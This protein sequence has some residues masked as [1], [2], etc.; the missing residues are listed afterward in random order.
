MILR[1]SQKLSTKIKAGTLPPLPLHENPFA[2][3]SAHVFAVRRTQHII[4]SNTKSLFSTVILAKGITSEDAFL[5]HALTGIREFLRADNQEF[6]YRCFIAPAASTV[7]FAKAFDRSVTGSMNEL[8]RQA[9][10]WL[11]GGMSLRNFGYELNGILLSA[12]GAGRSYG[13]PRDVFKMLLSNV[14]SAQ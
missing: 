11:E 1:L 6:V 2:D 14:E 5:D 7:A 13:K 10:D 8:M 4:L 9:T 3:W 12:L